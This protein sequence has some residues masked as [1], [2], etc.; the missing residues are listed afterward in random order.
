[1]NGLPEDYVVQYIYQYVGYVKERANGSLNGGCPICREGDSWGKKSRFYY[2]PELE[3]EKNTVYCHNC[4][5]SKNSI[6]FIMDVAGLSYKEVKQESENYDIIP[7]NINYE[8]FDNLID[9]KKTP[10]LP[11]NCINLFDKNQL[12]YYKDNE[13]VNTAVKYILSRKIHKSPNKPKA[14]YVS[15]DDYIHKNRLIIPYYDINGEIAWYQTRKLLE[16]DSPK[17]LSKVN[18]DRSMYNMD[19]IDDDYPYIFIFEGAID[20]MFVKNGTCLSGITESGDFTLTDTQESQL[21]AYPLH[22]KV[23]IMDSPYLDEAAR[24]KSN[25]LYNRGEKV[26]CWPKELGKVCKDFNDVIMKTGKTKIPQEFILR[27]LMNDESNTI[28]LDC[29]DLKDKLKSTFSC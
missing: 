1:M 6:G 3:G 11:D 17:Y 22:E 7:K 27:N 14:I 16:D 4:G 28:N 12:A 9:N 10:T 19:Q 25:M 8:E 29:N 23:W 21:C 13:V 26:F 20:A 24:K 5:Y 2:N 15:L 18:S